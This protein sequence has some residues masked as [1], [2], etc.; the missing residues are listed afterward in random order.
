MVAAKTT[1]PM[2]QILAVDVS[3]RVLPWRYVIK[4]Y[5]A[6]EEWMTVRHRMSP[7]ES[8]HS[9]RQIGDAV[10]QLHAI[11]FPAFGELSADGT[12]PA[13]VPYINAL[14][15]RA[16]HLLQKEIWRDLFLSALTQHAA[17]FSDVRQPS[18]CHEDLHGHNILFRRVQ[19]EWRLATILDFDKA[20]A[21][22]SESD[23]A[24]L[25][26]WTGMTDDE[27][28]PAYEAHHRI[29]SLYRQ[30]RLIYQL[31]WCLEYARPTPKHLADT[32]LVCMELGIPPLE[33]F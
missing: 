16:V 2:P 17:L 10:A 15:D 23:L 20:W 14:A 8:A 5:I 18:L 12:V 4:E 30:R 28:W 13:R 9:Y 21:G 19:G 6:G 32:R 29:D 25:E 27:F 33:H 26:F 3:C 24:K 11:D 1:I 31:L 22:H 7:A